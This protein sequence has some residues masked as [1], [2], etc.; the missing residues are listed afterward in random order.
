M[1]GAQRRHTSQ[2]DCTKVQ[3][4]GDDTKTEVVVVVIVTSM[5]WWSR[6]MVH[7]LPWKSQN[8]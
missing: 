5:Q 2:Y 4:F 8:P 7:S 6:A 1:F 3:V